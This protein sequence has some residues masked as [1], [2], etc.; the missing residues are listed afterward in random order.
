MSFLN[1]AIELANMGFHVFPLRPN[2]KLPLVKDFPNVATTDIEKIKAWWTCPIMGTEQPYNIG[3]STTKFGPATGYGPTHGAL[4]VVDVDDKGAKKGSDTLFEL[5]M[6]GLELPETFAQSTTTGG[7]HLVFWNK[8]AVKQ[9]VEILGKGLDIRSKGGYIVGA[10][11]KI[12]G[13]KY[14]AINTNIKDAPQWVIDACG[15]APE[16]KEAKKGEKYIPTEYDIS[17]AIH[18]LENEAPESVKGAAGDQTAYKVAAK[19]KDFGI[20]KEHCLDLMMTN[21][22]EGSGWTAEKLSLKIEHA[23]N[24]GQHKVGEASPTADFT[25]VATAETEEVSYLHKMNKE[26]ALVYVGGSHS[27]LNET[28]DEKGRAVMVL[29]SEITF[30]R[31]FS[32]YTVQ[33]NITWAEEW[34]DWPGRREYKGLCFAPGREPGNNYYNLWRG[35]TVEPMSYEDGN[36]EQQKGFDAFKEH[37]LK[38]ICAGNQEHFNWLM[39][40]F[41]HMIQ[42]PYE[43]PLTTVVFQGRKGVGKN[44]LVDRVG[45]LLGRTS[46]LVAHDGRYLTS[47]FNGHLE[48]CL[49]LVL[50][51]A[52]WSGDKSAE[53]KLKG[54]TTAP[55][56]MIERKGKEPY[57]VDNVTRLVIIGNEEWLVPASSDER[58]YAVFAVGEGNMQDGKYFHD[59]RINLDE[60]GGNKIL[61]HYLQNY[62]LSNVDVNDA[63]KTAALLEQ[64]VNSLDPFEKFWHSCLTEGELICSDFG[65]DWEDLDKDRLRLA[66]GRYCREA[67]IR[68]RLP[69]PRAIGRM[70][71]KL[72]PSATSSKKQEEGERKNIYKLPTLLES[73]R[74]WDQVMG[75]ESIWGEL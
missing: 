32:P 13:K 5:E 27:I 34:L 31:R 38:N 57:S 35:F 23:Y 49:C 40:Y 20:S 58:R 4:V 74:E 53:G 47:N 64:K 37:A 21:W 3:I 69:D 15:K 62:D 56:I 73:R 72:C 54:I 67:N 75:Q 25:P 30:K 26:Y 68:S 9:G 51:E 2:S 43:R 59:M 6:N 19:V 11:S 71:K 24:Y 8:E 55:E 50:D 63:P 1:S 14:S 70:L 29:L 36:K 12:D 65:A 66:F 17:R 41:A 33:K 60:K 22:F 7:R 46:Y 10:G 45:S 52:F 16:K 39:G 18:Y 44:A 42:K 61:L 48:S 28:V